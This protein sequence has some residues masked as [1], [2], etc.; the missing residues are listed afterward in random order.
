MPDK[1]KKLRA[2]LTDRINTKRA[3]TLALYLLPF[4]LI[5][6]RRVKNASNA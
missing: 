4:L 2:S 1:L 3:G 5:A 6:R